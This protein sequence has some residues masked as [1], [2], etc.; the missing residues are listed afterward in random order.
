MLK[1]MPLGDSLTAGGYNQNNQWKV[2]GGYRVELDSL[3]EQAKFDFV[4]VGTLHDG[5]AGFFN[6]AHE[7]HSGWR[8][9]QLTTSVAKWLKAAKPDV[10]L[11]MIG[12]NDII[13]DYDLANVGQRFA[14]LLSQIEKYVPNATIFAASPIPTENETWNSSLEDLRASIL[15]TVLQHQ[16]MGTRVE[17][18]DIYND[19]GIVHDRSDLIDGV[20]PNP[21]A[22]EKLSPIWAKAILNSQYPRK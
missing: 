15:Q 11:L 13:Q 8:I 16:Q 14:A 18:V 6:N 5:P 7:G 22:Y 2:G 19:A 17:F 3:L 20:H 21:Q 12:T 10:I 1:I 4:F 9:D